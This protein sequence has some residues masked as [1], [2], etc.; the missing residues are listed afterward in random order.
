MESPGLS[1]YATRPPVDVL[2]GRGTNARI[3]L[4]GVRF[5]M[6]VTS[7][8]LDTRVV[9]RQMFTEILKFGRRKL[10]FRSPYADISY[11]GLGEIQVQC[12]DWCALCYANARR[13]ANYRGHYLY[14][15]PKKKRRYEVGKFASKKDA[16]PAGEG[17]S[18]NWVVGRFEELYPAIHE[19][20]SLDRHDDGKKRET[21]TMLVL[22]DSGMLKA[23]FN[24]RDNQRAA[25]VGA[26]NLEGLFL[27]LEDGLQCDTLEWRPSK[28]AFKKR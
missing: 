9:Y 13:R 23:W 1:L 7:A 8:G 14:R 4:P 6:D 2:A 21:A 11:S 20:L 19:Y 17:G 3:L 28:A 12:E 5:A 24:D 22:C 16:K 26:T 10:M 18:S 27:A 15:S 25:W